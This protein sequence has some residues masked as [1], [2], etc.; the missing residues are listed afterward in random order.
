MEAPD[1]VA[2]WQKVFAEKMPTEVS[3]YQPVPTHS[4]ARI[5]WAAAQLLPTLPPGTPLRLLDVGGGDSFLMD[6]LLAQTHFAVEPTVLDISANALQRLQHRLGPNAQRVKWVVANA[7]EYKPGPQAFHIWHDRA[8]F[9]FLTQPAQQA[10]YAQAA[11]RGVV[12]GGYLIVGAFAAEIGPEK[13]SGLPV[14]RH[15]A[16]SLTDVFGPHFDLLE[17]KPVEHT[18]PFGTVQHFVFAILQRKA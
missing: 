13:C 14:C 3:W 16:K 11:A 10:H 12:A 2:H 6:N 7:A 8:A 9:H 18:T 4:L 17:T 15:S 1:L 5:E